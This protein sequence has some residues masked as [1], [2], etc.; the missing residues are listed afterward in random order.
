MPLEANHHI[1]IQANNTL[2]LTAIT[3]SG[4]VYKKKTPTHNNET[5][6]QSKKYKT[7]AQQVHQQATLTSQCHLKNKA[8]VSNH[9]YSLDCTTICKR[10]H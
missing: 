4:P 5:L 6:L 1:I 9:Q 10:K 3:T 8:A 7:K 2:H